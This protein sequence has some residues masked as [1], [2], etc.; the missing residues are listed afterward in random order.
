[1][2][3]TRDGASLLPVPGHEQEEVDQSLPRLDEEVEGIEL[4]PTD[5]DQVL[6]EEDE[7]MEEDS[8]ERN[9][10]MAKSL[11]NTWHKLVDEAKNVAVKQ[12]TFVEPVKSRA[13]KHVLIYCRLRS[14]GLPLYRLHTDR[15]R[16]FCSEQVQSWTRARDVVTTMTPGSSY[17]ANRRVEGEMNMIKKSIRTLISAQIGSL[18]Q[19]P[20][21]ARHIG[22]RRLRAQLQ[23]LGW[24]VGRLLRFG[25]QAFALRKSW[26]ARYAP[27][28][29]VR[30]EVKIL[31]PDMNSSLT[32]TGYLVQSVTSGRKFYTDDIIIPE[33]QQPAVD[34][35]VLYLPEREDDAPPRRQRRKAAQ[36]AL[37]MFSI[38]GERRI[39]EC[40]PEMFEPEKP[41]HPG[42]SSNGWTMATPSGS[43]SSSPRA[44]QDE[45]EDW[46]IGGGDVEGAPNSWDGGSRPTAPSSVSSAA[47]RTLHVNLTQYVEEEMAMLDGTS[48]DQSM[49]IAP[50]SEAIKMKA[51]VE[52]Q[53]MEAQELNVEKNQ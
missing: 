35:Q 41:Y 29:E 12:I 43:E 23:L 8:E 14:L 44:F 5:E 48:A 7:V 10:D 19:W 2:P 3:V 17:K 47:L 27:W 25:A 31:G 32:N 6:P 37:S 15:A 53:L 40:C 49:W 4:E 11:H 30:E 18:N 22:E 9:V 39:V 24:P 33:S 28:H 34:E 45:E 52:D 16:E 46:I 50:V 20:L 1:M 42:D 36:P 38:E 26:Q 21:I 13:V 51:L